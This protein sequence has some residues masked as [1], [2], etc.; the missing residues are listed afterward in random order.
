MGCTSYGLKYKVCSP[1]EWQQMKGSM[2]PYDVS[3]GDMHIANYGFVILDD[4]YNQPIDNEYDLEE[5]VHDLKKRA[6]E[7]VATITETQLRGIIKESITRILKENYAQAAQNRLMIT[8]EEIFGD[9]ED[10]KA[11]AL[12]ALQ[13]VSP[14]EILHMSKEELINLVHVAA[15]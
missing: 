13:D 7:R 2:D 12:N 9:D 11:S 3:I 10:S 14:E 8:A 6:R 15:M 4:V 1:D 5:I